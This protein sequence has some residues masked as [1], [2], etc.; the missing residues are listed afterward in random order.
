LSDGT[1]LI[2]FFPEEGQGKRKRRMLMKYI[3][4]SALAVAGFLT[5]LGLLAPPPASTQEKKPNIVVINPL[6]KNI[7]LE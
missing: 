3:A 5:V 1:G 7:D 2:G 6:V 4:K